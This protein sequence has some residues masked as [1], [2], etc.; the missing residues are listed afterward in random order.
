MKL[1]GLS[2]QI[3]L[4][5]M[6]MAFGITFLVVLTSYVVFYIAVSLWPEIVEETS[7]M[8]NAPDWAWIGVSTLAGLALATVVGLHL[9]RRILV[10]LNSVTESMRRVAQGDL[11]ARA[12]AGDRSLGEAAHLA[13]DFNALATQ[14]QRATQE[15]T[16]WNAAI[17]HELRT[18]VT[19]LRGRLQG[20]AEGVFAPD[21]TQFRSLLNQVDGLARLIEDL[22]AVSLAE[23]GHLHLK[24]EDTD[25]AAEVESVA[26][27][28]RDAL[29]SAGKSLVL[30]LD[31]APMRCDAMRMRQA[32]LALLDN[33]RRYAVPGGVRIRTRQDNGWCVLQV[34]DDGPG[35]A[36]GAAAQVF[37]AFRRMRD[38]GERGADAGSG[39]GLAVVAAIARAHQGQA[40]CQASVQGGT[41]FTLRWPVNVAHGAR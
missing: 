9:A 28:C 10:P 34:E 35:I 23:S 19:I 14:L 31:R 7:W 36:P 15:M 38:D 33:V 40:T 11:S 12:V 1:A 25:L 39:L 5:M 17:A 24:I 4:T 41:C 8:P 3:A 22:R 18:P 6:A 20:L 37:T 27:V 32:L 26:Q 21:D 2:R 30:D 16:F 13:D 29:Q